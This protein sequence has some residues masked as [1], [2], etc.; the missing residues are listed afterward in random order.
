MRQLI[1]VGFLGL[2]VLSTIQLLE[3]LARQNGMAGFYAVLGSIG[4]VMWIILYYSGYLLPTKVEETQAGKELPKQGEDDIN[5]ILAKLNRENAGKSA[6]YATK[7]E[8]LEVGGIITGSLEISQRLA[9]DTEEGLSLLKASYD[10]L[11]AWR[12]QVESEIIETQKAIAAMSVGLQA[13]EEK[14]AEPPQ[15]P[16]SMLLQGKL[17]VPQKK[18]PTDFEIQRLNDTASLTMASYVSNGNN[19]LLCESVDKSDNL[20]ISS[21]KLDKQQVKSLIYFL[22]C[23]LHTGSIVHEE[24]SKG[25]VCQTQSCS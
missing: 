18:M 23:W 21:Y 16:L 25:D 13:M 3:S 6:E 9:K 17:W 19:S 2:A 1:G 7:K 11:Q 15:D 22:Q 14:L 4:A 8:L 24:E 12:G 20:W 5:S 10:A